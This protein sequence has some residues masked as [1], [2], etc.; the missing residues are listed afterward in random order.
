MEADIN[1]NNCIQYSNYLTY[2]HYVNVCNGKE[3][4]VYYGTG[5]WLLVIVCVILFLI[6]IGFVFSSVKN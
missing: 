5:D 3:Y 6:L 4:D 1:V 2:T